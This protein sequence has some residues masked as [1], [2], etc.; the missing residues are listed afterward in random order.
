MHPRK[1]PAQRP[2]RVSRIARAQ[3]ALD[4]R[5]DDPAAIGDPA[6]RGQPRGKRG[7]AVRFLQGIAGGNQQPN[8][9][10]PQPLQR[11]L[12]HMPVPFMRRVERA[13]EDADPQPVAMAEPGRRRGR[14]EDQ[15]RTCPVPVT[16][17]R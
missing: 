12:R 10:Q 11:D 1:Q 14:I 7:H 8:L 2:Q 16:M 17:V 6:R 5:R 4:R 9:V 15:G 13:A 3:L